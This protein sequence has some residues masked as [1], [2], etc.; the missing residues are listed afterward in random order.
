[1]NFEYIF[2]VYVSFFFIY[3]HRERG[4]EGKQ[5]YFIRCSVMVVFNVYYTTSPDYAIHATRPS[6]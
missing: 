3:I 6:P 1:M 4:K 2:F 5:K